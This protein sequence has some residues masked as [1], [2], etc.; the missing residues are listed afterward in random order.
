[1]TM[2]KVHRSGNETLVYKDGK[3]IEQKANPETIYIIQATNRGGHPADIKE[4][5][6]T[7]PN[8]RP[9]CCG[10]EM[11]C[12]GGVIGNRPDGIRGDI[13]HLWRCDRCGMEVND[14]LSE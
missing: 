7:F 11:Y 8:G 3:L 5:V 1:M 13:E 4:A 12:A 6:L 10:I 2:F 14:I 9:V